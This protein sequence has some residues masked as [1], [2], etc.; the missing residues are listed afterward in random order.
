[1]QQLIVMAVVVCVA[2]ALSMAI[3]GGIAFL[4]FRA[5]PPKERLAHAGS[6]ALTRADVLTFVG[7][8]VAA[9]H[10]TYGGSRNKARSAKASIH[11]P[12]AA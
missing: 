10:V 11:L 5:L 12:A 8:G 9:A 1:M 6:N 7:A 3:V 4:L 2:T